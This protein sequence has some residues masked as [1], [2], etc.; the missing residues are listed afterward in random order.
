MIFRIRSSMIEIIIKDYLIMM[1]DRGLVFRNYLR[2]RISITKGRGKWV[3]R[4]VMIRSIEVMNRIRYQK[5]KYQ[6]IVN[7]GRQM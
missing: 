2:N 3:S 6:L 4:I 7:R 5:G 1:V